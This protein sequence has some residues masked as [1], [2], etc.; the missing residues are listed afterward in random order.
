MISSIID[1]GSFDQDSLEPYR[2]LR[3]TAEHLAQGIFVAE[4]GK[5]VRRLFESALEIR[6]ILMTAEWLEPFRKDLEKRPEPVTVF[7]A[8]EQLMAGIVGFQFHRGIMAVA[9]VPAAIPLD[10]ACS[11]EARPRLF[12]ALDGLTN[13][14]NTGVIAR[15]CAACGVQALIKGETSADPYLRR[16]VR[17]S[18]GTV[19]RLPVIRSDHLS[20]SLKSLHDEHGFL[21]VAAHPRPGSASL[22][23]IDLTGDVCLVFGHEDK[24]VSEKIVAACTQTAIIPMAAGIDSFNVA[25]ACAI[26]LYEACRQRLVKR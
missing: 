18:M 2:T 5:V 1:I 22:H 3:R 11:D 20:A 17:N 15:N 24:G 23:E 26:A 10:S 25:S 12:V 21:I 16:A 19:F 6:S 8:S 9:K 13:A 14:E 4:G 7:R